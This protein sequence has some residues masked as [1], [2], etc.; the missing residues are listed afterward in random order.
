MSTPRAQDA[1]PRRAT[2]PAGTGE[3]ERIGPWAALLVWLALFL[4]ASVRAGSTWREFSATIDEGRHVAAAL[5]V[6]Q[7]Q[8]YSV[9]YGNPPFPRYFTGLLPYMAGARVPTPE[10]ESAALAPYLPIVRGDR[11]H[12]LGKCVLESAPDYWDVLSRARAGNLVFLALMMAIVYRWSADLF[13]RAAG[14]LASAFI[15][16]SPL[17]LGHGALATTDVAGSST[18]VLGA[19]LLW[20]WAVRPGVRSCLLAA[21]GFAL[22]FSSKPTTP[23]FLLLTGGL[24][25][26]LA[27][28]RGWLAHPRLGFRPLATAVARGVLFGTVFFL[29]VWSIYLFQVGVWAERSPWLHG[30]IDRRLAAGTRLNELAHHVVAD[31]PLPLPFLPDALKIAK[32]ET[33]RPWASFLFGEV[34]LGSYAYFVWG[35]LLKSTPFFLLAA[36]TSGLL[37]MRG[38]GRSWWLG[39]GGVLVGAAV[40]LAG[41]SLSRMNIGVRHVMPV[42]AFLAIMSGVLFA[43]GTRRA[44]QAL[45]LLLLGGHAVDSALAHPNYMAY[46]TPFVRGNEAH[47]LRDSNLDWGQD[48]ARLARYCQSNGI[49]QLTGSV[50]GTRYATSP[51]EFGLTGYR[52]LEPTER[53]S[54]WFAISYN[55]LAG[56]GLPTKEYEALEAFSWLAE[57]SPRARIGNSILLYNLTP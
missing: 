34:T 9:Y 45:A 29:V 1:V 12:A 20:R 39:A 57:H 27:R 6:W 18:A 50:F 15:S 14:L 51:A 28:G 23:A 17:V 25:F 11:E 37:W 8:R 3:A 24:F 47:Y 30:A 56:I 4:I 26:V 32:Q 55:H 52:E 21:V 2:P 31:V 19:Y 10:A 13:G 54:G 5:E 46:F 35:M 43:P 44:V 33:S 38:R 48:I 36:L 53:P 41:P 16:S 22:A 40:F 49:E 42:Y 7:N